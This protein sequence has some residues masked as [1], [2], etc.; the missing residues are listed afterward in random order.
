VSVRDETTPSGAVGHPVVVTGLRF[1]PVAASLVPAVW[2]ASELVALVVPAHTTVHAMVGGRV[3][4]AEGATAGEVVIRGHDELRFHYRHLVPST[5]RVS[6][7][8]VVEPGAIL[9]VVSPAPAGV[10]S[11]SLLVGVEAPDGRWLPLDDHL[12]GAA[13]PSGLFL[14]PPSVERNDPLVRSL[15][16]GGV[17]PARAPAGPPRRRGPHESEG[18]G[19]APTGMPEPGVVPAD[20][21]SA[22]AGAAPDTGTPI[23]DP[24]ARLAGRA[25]PRPGSRR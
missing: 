10:A 5:V 8:L 4:G 21:T 15:R 2:A 12:V 6:E 16:R 9:G 25:R 7:G 22:D 23:D 17:D 18:P 13:D 1:L 19:P 20:R 3:V 11:S 14:A 24:I